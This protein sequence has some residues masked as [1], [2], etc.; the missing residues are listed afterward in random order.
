MEAKGDPPAGGIGTR[1][2]QVHIVAQVKGQ[3]DPLHWAL[4]S[5]S[6]YFT[7]TLHSMSIPHGEESFGYTD[8][9]IECTA[10]HQFFAVDIATTKARRIRGVNA[11]FIRRHPHDSHERM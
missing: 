4:D 9:Q 8:W 3:V 2:C 10:C 7:V 1:G 5:H 11:G 6:S